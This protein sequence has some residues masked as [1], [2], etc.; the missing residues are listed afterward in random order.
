VPKG[1]PCVV[2]F[3]FSVHLPVPFR[4]T[5]SLAFELALTLLL[6]AVEVDEG[7]WRAL[8]FTCRVL[9]GGAGARGQ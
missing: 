6:Q 5:L 9:T 7:N 2:P 8:T 1:R 3:G 4:L